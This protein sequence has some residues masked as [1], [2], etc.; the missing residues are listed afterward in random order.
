[1]QSIV[2]HNLQSDVI[3]HFNELHS[4]YDASSIN[5]QLG[6]KFITMHPLY[7]RV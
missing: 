6:S 4:S 5:W 7:I 3:S 2:Q 1:M